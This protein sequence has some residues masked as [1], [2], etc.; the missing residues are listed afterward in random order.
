MYEYLDIPIVEQL[1]T[2]FLPELGATL[3]VSREVGSSNILKCRLLAGNH[4]DKTINSNQAEGTLAELYF[5]FG[6]TGADTAYL[7]HRFVSMHHRG[8]GLATK[9]LQ[10]AESILADSN[11]AKK[12][13][14]NT[15]QVSVMK[16]LLKSDFILSNED[17]PQNTPE[18]IALVKAYLNGD[19]TQLEESLVDND[20]S[21]EL[22]LFK[23]T[24]P[25]E[26]R[27]VRNAITLRFEKP[28]GISKDT[29]KD[30]IA[31][32][33]QTVAYVNKAL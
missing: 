16:F 26:R 30:V 8:K 29:R 27:R 14:I 24:L 23:K 5:Y 15:G 11:M 4:L 20:H 28:I 21:T 12:I 1:K 7:G 32:E 9:L 3:Y 6:T 13:L 33:N 17:A 10:Q 31:I 2:T 22:Y 25:V 19:R 18:N